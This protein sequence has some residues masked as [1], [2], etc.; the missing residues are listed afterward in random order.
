MNQSRWYFHPI[1]IFVASILALVTSL[2]LYIYWYIEVSTG[3]QT[4]M[5]KFDLDSRQILAADTWIVIM[6]LSMLV[7][8]ILLGIF[9]IF[10]YNLKTLQ[11]YRLQNNFINNF[12]HELK[13]PVTSLRLYLETFQKHALPRESQLKYIDYMIQDTVRLNTTISSILNLAKIES[14]SYQGNF[15]LKDLRRAVDHFLEENAHLIKNCRIQTR[16]ST[17]REFLYRIDPALFDMLLMNLITNA[18]KYNTADHPTL[19][20]DLSTRRGWILLAFHDNGIGIAQKDL[21]RI[22]KKFYQVGQADDMTV[23][24]SGIGLYLVQS[25]ARIHGG[26]LTAR[27]EGPGHGSVFTLALPDKY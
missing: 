12:T 3:L 1:L 24:G 2:F 10:F 14:K 5:R 21:K 4:L 25:I 9:I 27:S 16:F 26:T 22:F 7:G 17:E 18:V 11:L 20:I 6:V 15:T 19:D 13:T 23:R 8:F